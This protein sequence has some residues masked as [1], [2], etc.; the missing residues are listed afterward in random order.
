[1]EIRVESL[2]EAYA[3]AARERDHYLRL[4]AGDEIRVIICYPSDFLGQVELFIQTLKQRGDYR[5]L[6]RKHGTLQN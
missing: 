5:D 6:W 3:R 1:M 4:W 2:H